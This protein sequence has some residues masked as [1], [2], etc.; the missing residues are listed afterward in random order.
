MYFYE[1]THLRQGFGGQATIYI[2]YE[3]LVCKSRQGPNFT[4]GPFD[5]VHALASAAM[6]LEVGRLSIKLTFEYSATSPADIFAVFNAPAESPLSSSSLK[7]R[8]IY[9]HR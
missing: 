6:P 3:K 2:G 9:I 8:I 4:P 1:S 5:L 7:V